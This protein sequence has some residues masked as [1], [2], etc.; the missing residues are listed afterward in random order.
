MKKRHWYAVCTQPQRERLAAE[1]LEKQGFSVFFPRALK[2]VRH[3]R[4][5]TNKHVS[6]F[7]GYIF[8]SLDLN[9]D[10]WR[11][12]NGTIGVR[13]LVMAGERPA[14]APSDFIEHL[15]EACDPANGLVSRS[16]WQPGEKVRV[17]SGPFGDIVG[18]IARLDG[19]A[20][21]RVLMEMIGGMTP[22][23]TLST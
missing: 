16:D 12:V 1:Q 9:A 14:V 19:P 23:E 4:R 11:Q 17:M 10:R 22:L 7:P 3:A 13:T 18:V 21:I 5:V 6:Y 8:V 15:R 20:R 2:T